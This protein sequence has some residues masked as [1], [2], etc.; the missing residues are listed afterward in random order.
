MYASTARHVL[1]DAITTIVIVI[2]GGGVVSV[3]LT[4]L[5]T[6]GASFASCHKGCFGVFGCIMQ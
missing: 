1:V 6:V 4:S 2:K 5:D 3:A